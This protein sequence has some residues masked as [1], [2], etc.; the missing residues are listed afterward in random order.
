MQIKQNVLTNVIRQ[1]LF[2]K[3]DL[4]YLDIN[5]RYLMNNIPN[6]YND[7][8]YQFN[9][10]FCEEYYNKDTVIGVV[11]EGE[12]EK[13]GELNFGIWKFSK[14]NSNPEYLNPEEWIK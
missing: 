6:K 4:Q 2:D 8:F 3:K 10:E 9:D 13:Y 11:A 5:E 12:D 1:H 7:E 14:N